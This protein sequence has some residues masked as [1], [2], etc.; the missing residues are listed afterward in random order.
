[1][2]KKY[3]YIL[4]GIFSLFIIFS[5]LIEKN[6]LDKRFKSRDTKLLNIKINEVID[7]YNFKNEMYIRI[8]EFKTNRNRGYIK[9]YINLK[10][11]VLSKN[12]NFLEI[13]TKLD[14]DKKY[15][16]HLDLKKMLKDNN[17]IYEKEF[18]IGINAE[19][20]IDLNFDL[21]ENININR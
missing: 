6:I 3:I 17:S 15:I 1:M 19:N 4:I 10:R 20:I 7:K 2:K 16:K 11:E 5:P 8:T 21:I 13:S 14:N 9:G 12:I 18:Q